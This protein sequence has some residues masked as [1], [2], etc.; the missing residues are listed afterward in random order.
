MSQASAMFAPAPAATPLRDR[1][2]KV[3]RLARSHGA[4]VE[5]LPGAEA[6]ARTGEDQHPRIAEVA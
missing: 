4:V 6:S 3:D 5:V 2:A 1:L